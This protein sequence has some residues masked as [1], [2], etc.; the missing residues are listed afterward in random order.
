MSVPSDP[1]MSAEELRRLMAA[2]PSP[3]SADGFP[4]ALRT[5]LV[6]FHEAIADLTAETIRA[7]G[8]WGWMS[9]RCS[10]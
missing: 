7:F 6:E 2:Q 9:T 10:G 8:C 5:L 4:P 1:W 3:T